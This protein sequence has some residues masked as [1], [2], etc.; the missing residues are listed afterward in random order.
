LNANE[1][2]ST[3]SPE[4]ANLAKLEQLEI[5]VNLL[6][7]PL[8]SALAE[9]GSLRGL[10]LSAN[11]LTGPAV[12]LLTSWPRLETFWA[13][14]TRLS[15]TI[16]DNIGDA[17]PGLVKFAI[18]SSELTGTI[19]SSFGMLTKLDTVSI[20]CP[21]LNTTLPWYFGALTELSTLLSPIVAPHL[22][23]QRALSHVSFSVSH[24]LWS[25]LYQER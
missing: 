15:G 6:S 5:S 18:S 23:R 12:P 3:L 21:S 8:P 4:I 19:P 22:G 20:V 2:T 9:V 14:N 1:F 24:T 11:D 13:E 7:G 17:V 25:P 10:A 16:P